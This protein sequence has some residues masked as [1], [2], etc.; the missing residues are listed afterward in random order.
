MNFAFS[1]VF[2]VSLGIALY[3]LQGIMSQQR[4]KA[5]LLGSALHLGI[6]FFLSYRS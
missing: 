1:N 4:F 5:L 2:A 6:M 3:T